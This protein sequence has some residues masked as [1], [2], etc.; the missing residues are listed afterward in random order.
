MRTTVF[1]KELPQAI[2]MSPFWPT[3]GS[4]LFQMANPPGEI[5]LL[6]LR[7]PDT[8]LF[9]KERLLVSELSPSSLLQ[10]F[11]CNFL[12]QSTTQRYLVFKTNK[13]TNKKTNKQ[14][15]KTKTSLEQPAF[16]QSVLLS[17]L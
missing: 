2:D 11:P 13:Q 1:Y 10:R 7:V 8:I 5:Y 6:L 4:P 3:A 15:N 14:T 17:G 16:L 12:L 9:Y